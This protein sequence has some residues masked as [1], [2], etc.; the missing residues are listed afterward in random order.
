MQAVL[1]SRHRSKLLGFDKIFLTG[2]CCARTDWSQ[3][4]TPRCIMR[5]LCYAATE[6]AI[7]MNLIYP[8]VYFYLREMKPF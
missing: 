2:V 6:I 7:L 8:T 1:A 5:L 3:Q 4:E